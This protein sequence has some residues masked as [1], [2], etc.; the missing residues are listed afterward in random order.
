MFQLM[1]PNTPEKKNAFNAVGR[2]FRKL[3]KATQMVDRYA[4]DPKKKKQLEKAQ[5]N[6]ENALKEFEKA[7]QG[8]RNVLIKYL[9]KHNSKKNSAE[10]IEKEVN[11]GDYGPSMTTRTRYSITVDGEKVTL[12]DHVEAYATVFE[13]GF[14]VK[15]NSDKGK[16]EVA[17]VI[18][19]AGLSKPRI[20]ILSTISGF[21]GSFSTA[22]SWDRAVLTWGF[23]QWTGGKE[24]DLTNAL[25]IIK[26]TDSNAFNKR[27]KRYG[28]DVDE[29]GTQ[30]IISEKTEAGVKITKGDAA[31]KLIGTSAK[32]IAVMSSA[33]IDP[34][35][36]LGEIQA[37]NELEIDRPL[38]RMISFSLSSK[39]DPK[40]KLAHKVKPIQLSA[41]LGDIITSEY[42]VGIMANHTVHSGFNSS[43]VKEIAKRFKAFVKEKELG[44]EDMTDRKK[45]WPFEQKLY[46]MFRDKDRDTAFKDKCSVE[47]DSFK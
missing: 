12:Y 25:A 16:K 40:T 17:E 38:N 35:I 29:K 47:F 42:G 34:Q 2:A 11:K 41:R 30:L 10:E 44:I 36:Q 1:K 9:K 5:K 45:L 22:Q 33:G 37:A 13:M 8:I 19:K 23:V 4:A 24:S 27:F 20:N 6:V 32:L 14:E 28:I 18:N 26:K 39:T 3:T 31:A 15:A 7:K 43:M 21:E 46:P